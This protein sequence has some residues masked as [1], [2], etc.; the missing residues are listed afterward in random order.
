MRKSSVA[1]RLASLGVSG[2]ESLGTVAR[3]AKV[4]S[5]RSQLINNLQAPRL[6][7]KELVCSFLAIWSNTAP[8]KPWISGAILFV[9]AKIIQGNRRVR[10]SRTLVATCST[11]RPRTHRAPPITVRRSP[12]IRRQSQDRIRFGRREW[13]PWDPENL[14]SWL[15]QHEHCWLSAESRC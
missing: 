9:A 15:V 1:H 5:P 11:T 14:R 2:T 4:A 10:V 7:Q 13:P 12:A 8:I 3:S 6:F